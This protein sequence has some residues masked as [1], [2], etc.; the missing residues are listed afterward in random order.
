MRFDRSGSAG[1]TSSSPVPRFPSGFGRRI[2][3][4]V[5][6]RRSLPGVFVDPWPL[7]RRDFPSPPRQR[8]ES[9]SR[10]TC[11]PPTWPAPRFPQCP[12]CRPLPRP[13][14]LSEHDRGFGSI[15]SALRSMKPGREARGGRNVCE[16][17]QSGVDPC[18][19][20]KVGTWMRA[21]CAYTGSLAR[22]AAAKTRMPPRTAGAIAAGASELSGRLARD[23]LSPGL[24]ERPESTSQGRRSEHPRPCHDR[25]RLR[26]RHGRN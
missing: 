11:Q 5:R 1:R 19:L 14:R 23:R 22:T 10:A 6:T 20:G 7:R 9:P 13:F 3:L 26:H 16:T 15:G 24:A 25:R 18:W 2:P 12:D 4:F 21:V 17:V 8:V